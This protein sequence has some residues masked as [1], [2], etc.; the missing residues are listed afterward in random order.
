MPTHAEQRALPYTPA[1]MYA[2]VADIERYPEFLPWCLDCRIVERKKAQLIASLT[3]GYR[4]FR[5]TFIS[6][7][8]LNDKGRTIEV[9]YVKGP[10]RYLNN[11]W[12]FKATAAGCIVDF[13]ID[14]EFRT[15]F[16]QKI[17]GVFFNEAVKRMITAF[18]T[19]AANLYAEGG[20][21]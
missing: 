10:F 9:R 6:E 3:I 21:G 16:L 19:R 15:P 17:M 8:D 20:G 11:T 18:E 14:F 2:L 4:I 5:E 7:V 13:A 12:A 1:Q